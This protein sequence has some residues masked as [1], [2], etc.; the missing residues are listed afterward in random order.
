VEILAV[1]KES[2]IGSITYR[3]EDRIGR[4]PVVE[5]TVQPP[6]TREHPGTKRRKRVKEYQVYRL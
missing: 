4:T 1:D 6:A 2:G 3:I 5:E